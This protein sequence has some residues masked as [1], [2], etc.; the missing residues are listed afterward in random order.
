M[1]AKSAAQRMARILTIEDDAV[2]AREIAL[3]LG[4]AGNEVDCVGDGRVGLE[5]ALGS[6]YDAI[7]LDRMLP[8][9]RSSVIAS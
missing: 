8:G 4:A 7:T 6:H 5:R 9:M 2:T 3:E 1:P